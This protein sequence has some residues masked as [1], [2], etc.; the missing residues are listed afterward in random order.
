PRLRRMNASSGVRIRKV[1]FR[2]GTDAELSALHAVE[3]PVETERGSD[4]MPRTLDSYMAFA[5][6]LPSQFSDHSWLAEAPEGMPVAIG[7]CWY[8]SAGDD[9]RGMECD[10]LVLP[11]HRRHRIGSE[12]L[13]VICAQTLREDR[14]LLTWSTF[15]R[16][17]AG[18]AFSRRVGA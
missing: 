7:Y 9:T 5:R 16:V 17:P 6:N 12:L 4:R 8:N 15:D 2:D 13:A 14:P 10:V 18:E 1:G 11:E 3:V